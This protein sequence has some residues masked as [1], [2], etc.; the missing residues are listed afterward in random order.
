MRAAHVRADH[1]LRQHARERLHH[2]GKP[3]SLVAAMRLPFAAQRQNA[4]RF[5][6]QNRGIHRVSI[7]A[8]MPLSIDRPAFGHW[9]AALVVHFDLAQ[10]DHGGRCIKPEGYGSAGIQN[11]SGLVPSIISRPNVGTIIG[12]VLVMENAASPSRAAISG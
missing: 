1:A 3:I 2:N 6:R 5:A 10:C 8:N 11:A 4:A 9:L 7:A 12:P